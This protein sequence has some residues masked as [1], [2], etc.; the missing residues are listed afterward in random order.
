[1]PFKSD[2]QRKK[3]FSLKSKGKNGSW[4]CDEWAKETGN[5]PLSKKAKKKSK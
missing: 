5:K 2:A 3:C 1:M 4:N